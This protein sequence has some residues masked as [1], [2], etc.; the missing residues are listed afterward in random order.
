MN[1]ITLNVFLKKKGHFGSKIEKAPWPSSK[2]L[3]ELGNIFVISSLAR[4]LFP[5]HVAQIL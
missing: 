5:F 3:S 4:A 2:L 1:D